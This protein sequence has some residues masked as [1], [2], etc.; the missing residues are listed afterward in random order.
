MNLLLEQGLMQSSASKAPRSVTGIYP[1]GLNLGSK[2]IS[3]CW[4]SSVVH[5]ARAQKDWQVM[6]TKAAHMLSAGG[7]R[8]SRALV[9]ECRCHK[10]SQP[11]RP[12]PGTRFSHKELF[13]R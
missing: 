8:A 11:D 10:C 4:R 9:M 5:S 13:V 6:I 2:R 1:A 12:E 7:V 3:A